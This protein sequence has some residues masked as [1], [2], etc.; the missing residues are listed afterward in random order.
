MQVNTLNI[1]SGNTCVCCQATKKISMQKSLVA[2]Y[3]WYWMSISEMASPGILLQLRYKLTQRSCLQLNLWF[4]ELLFRWKVAYC[5][6]FCWL[7]I[8]QCKL[9]KAIGYVSSTKTIITLHCSSVVLLFLFENNWGWGVVLDAQKK[10]IQS[11]HIPI[12]QLRWLF[13][14]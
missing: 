7:P 1:S 14:F 2:S 8:Q 3:C 13:N 10:T 11:A 12:I 4:D 6:F 9:Y 5:N